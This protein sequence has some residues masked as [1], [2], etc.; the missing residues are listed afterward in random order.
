MHGYNVDVGVVQIAEKGKNGS[1]SR[2]QLEVDFVCNLGLNRIYIQS[3]YSIP[4]AEKREQKIRSFQK[5]DDSFRKI[6]VTRDTALPWYDEN[7]I[8]TV[9]VYGF[10]LDQTILE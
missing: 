7:G 2:R 1:V 10:L 8:L 5:I 6:I 3:A 9:N 4:N